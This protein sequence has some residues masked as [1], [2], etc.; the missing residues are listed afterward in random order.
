MVIVS[1]YSGDSET[2]WW[3]LTTGDL[4][5]CRPHAT[6]LYFLLLIGTQPV[7]VSVNTGPFVQILHAR[8]SDV[9]GEEEVIISRPML[10]LIVGVT[11]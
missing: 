6:E 3:L 10:A 7:K 2:P 1:V 4:A 9:D 8:S 5:G 11:N